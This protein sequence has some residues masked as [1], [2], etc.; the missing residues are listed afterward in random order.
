MDNKKYGLG[1]LGLGS[2]GVRFGG[3]AFVRSGHFTIECL[4]DVRQ[5]KVDAA[6]DW[7]GDEGLLEHAVQGYT[8]ID[9]FLAHP[10]LDVVIVATPDFAHAEC[11]VRVLKA[12]KHLYLE[13]PMAQTIADC[14][15]I[16]EAWRGSDTVFMVGLELRYCTLMQDC[17]ALIDAGEIGRIILGTVVDNV[18][19]GGQY[20]F[21]GPRRRKDY[22]ISLIL[23]KGTHS[24]DLANWLIGDSP[25][26]VYASGGLDVY[27]GDAPNDKRCRD[28]EIRFTCPDF[29]EADADGFEKPDYCAFARE[30]DVSDNSL[31][32]V[33]YANGARLSYMECHFTPEYTREFMFVGDKGK[34]EAF[35]DNE[36]N[37]KIKLWKRFEKEPQIFYPGQSA[38]G[39]GGGDTGILDEFYLSLQAGKPSMKGVRGARDSAAIAIAAARSEESGLPV[40]IPKVVYPEGVAL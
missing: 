21:H 32:L 7:L 40:E 39:H 16:I 6:I 22:I 33:D 31:V 38:G 19:V 36:Q 13:K 9:A 1:I 8:D 23:E 34:L 14:D 11:A 18:S 10:G 26:K 5:D 17:K 27:G 12:K 30:C 3:G 37:F 25:R 4:C 24:L 28:C 29:I 2:R 15:R 35:Y 20:Y